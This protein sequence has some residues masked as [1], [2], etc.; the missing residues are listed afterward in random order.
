M[1]EEY[2]Y[3]AKMYDPQIGRFMRPDPLY[4]KQLSYADLLGFSWHLRL[5]LTVVVLIFCSCTGGRKAAQN[6]YYVEPFKEQE[7]KLVL[8]N[9]STFN[10]GDVTGCN[11]FG[12]TGE[13]RQKTDG[14]LSY[15]ILDSVKIQSTLS[16]FN[17]DLIFSIRSGDTAWVINSE[18]IFIHRQPFI[19]TSNKNKNLV[20]IRYKKLKEYYIGLLGQQGFIRVFGNGKGKREAKKRLLDCNLPDNNIRQ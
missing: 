2:D 4:E 3:K 8:K 5:E 19:L 10:F 9:D 16:G 14:S 11:Q 13:Y 18:R 17:S 15:F 1:L 20:K 6:Y 12:F 7:I